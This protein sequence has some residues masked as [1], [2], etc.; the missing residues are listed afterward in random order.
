MPVLAGVWCIAIACD[1]RSR[2]SRGVGRRSAS[3]LRGVQWLVSQASCGDGVPRG[4]AWC[5]EAHRQLVMRVVWSA[6]RM[7]ACAPLLLVGWAWQWPLKNPDEL[8]EGSSGKS[9][10]KRHNHVVPF[11]GAGS[12]PLSFRCSAFRLKRSTADSCGQRWFHETLGRSGAS[13]AGDV[14]HGVATCPSR[15]LRQVSRTG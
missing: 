3:S 14:V 4:A 15:R 2:C 7:P 13:C 10:Q 8:A 12:M 9:R 5:R 6:P 11:L 1:Q